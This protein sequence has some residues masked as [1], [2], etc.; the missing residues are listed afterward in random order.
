MILLLFIVFLVVSVTANQSF[1]Y[2]KDIIGYVVNKPIG[3]IVPN[4]NGKGSYSVYPSLVE[5]LH[6]DKDTGVISGIPKK[7]INTN[8]TIAFMSN[9]NSAKLESVIYFTG[10]LVD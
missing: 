1:K 9:N 10:I 5:G 7:S 8:Y 2:N 3:N 6:L 4:L